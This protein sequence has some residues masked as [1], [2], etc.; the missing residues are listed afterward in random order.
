MDVLGRQRQSSQRRCDKRRADRRD[1]AGP[2]SSIRM[3]RIENEAGT[4][5]VQKFG[6]S[7][8]ATPELRE[9][10]AR[11]VL[12]A[13]DH[14]RRPVVVTSAMGRLPAPYATDSL[15]ALAPDAP[16]GPNRDLL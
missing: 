8:L 1:R 3:S 12:E 9:L 15:L 11:R 5:V 6:G 16:A 4:L 7:S 14:G 13:I 10:A 2:R